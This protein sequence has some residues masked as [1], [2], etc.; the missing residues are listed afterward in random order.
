MQFWRS[1]QKIPRNVRNDIAWGP[2]FV[3]VLYSLLKPCFLLLVSLAHR[4]KSRQ[5]WRTVVARSP[6]VFRSNLKTFEE[7]K[8]FSLQSLFVHK[9]IFWHVDWS[10]GNAGERDSLTVKNNHSK[11]KKDQKIGEFLD[12]II[13]PMI[14]WDTRVQIWQPCWRNSA[15]KYRIYHLKIESGRTFLFCWNC[16]WK[17]STI[18]GSSFFQETRSYW[19]LKCS[20]DHRAN[21]FLLNLREKLL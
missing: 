3:M 16:F 7:L 12:K 15:R 6:K 2:N 17:K 4:L 5:R 10:F 8:N 11:N 9:M 18:S 19:E 21:A 14:S 1:C 13:S 20:F